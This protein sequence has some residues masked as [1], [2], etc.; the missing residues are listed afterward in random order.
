MITSTSDAST[1]LSPN[2]VGGTEDSKYDSIMSKLEGINAKLLKLDTLESIT[3]S[4]QG[5]VSQ[6]NSRMEKVSACVSTVQ[7][8]LEKFE[9]KWGDTVA[10]ITGRIWNWKNFLNHGRTNSN[11]LEIRWPTTSK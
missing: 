2:M 8:D 6:G 7:A 4:L 1:Q 10:S 3:V 9:K 11:L 5:E